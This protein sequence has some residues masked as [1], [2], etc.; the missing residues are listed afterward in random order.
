MNSNSNKQEE[1][2][3]SIFDKTV[4]D[5]F[6]LCKKILNAAEKRKLSSSEKKNPLLFRLEKYE[7]TYSKTEPDEHI[8]YF[9]NIYNRYRKTI[10]L[11]P[12]RDNWLDN[13][14]VITYGEECGLKT[15]V[16][17][18][19]SA[20]YRSAC[21]TRDE[22]KDELEGLPIGQDDAIELSYPKRY[23]YYLYII[24]REII[25]SETEK[26]KLNTHVSTLENEL[27]ISSS[28]GLLGGNNDALSGIFDMAAN[29]AEKVS[30]QKIPRDKMPGKNDFG[31]MLGQITNDPKTKNM[32]GAMMQKLQNTENLSDIVTTLVDNLGAN[33]SSKT[34]PNVES[35]NQ[36]VPQ[37][38]NT[39]SSSGSSVQADVNDEFA[40]FE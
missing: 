33:S 7:R 31:K 34:N 37:I 21:K 20:I 4:L 28:S 18:F 17:F 24:F 16:N 19:V 22:V 32:L 39:P 40:D 25:D 35:Q 38:E 2:D 27:G 26:N 23:L 29:M 30:G 14:I 11:G 12:Q 8:G 6:K 9:Q 5:L 15:E 10:L 1:K 3:L 36:M 13:D